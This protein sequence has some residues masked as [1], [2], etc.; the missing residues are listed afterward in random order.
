MSISIVVFKINFTRARL[1][2]IHC[3][4]SYLYMLYIKR[5]RCVLRERISPCEK[6]L[7]LSKSTFCAI[8]S[9][10]SLP[11]AN[12]LHSRSSTTI[13][14]S[15]GGICDLVS[16]FLTRAPPKRGM[17]AAMLFVIFSRAITDRE[18]REA[19]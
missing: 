14:F 7:F 9:E 2:I 19:L 17:P 13:K 11:I 15:R 16:L 18:K 10:L 1:N 3:P 5:G 4:I 6:S 12:Y 8:P